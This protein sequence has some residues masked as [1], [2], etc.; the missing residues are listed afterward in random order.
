MMMDGSD[1]QA[2]IAPLLNDLRNGDRA[3]IETLR[4]MIEAGTITVDDVKRAQSG[5][6]HMPAQPRPASP[7]Q[8]QQP[9]PVKIASDETVIDVP[10][11]K[12]EAPWYWPFEKKQK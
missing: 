9:Q 10:V 3:A 12:D 7:S 2:L 5:G 4:Q 8:Q 1:R 11:K 6:H